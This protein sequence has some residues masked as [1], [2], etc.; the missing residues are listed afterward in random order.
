MQA[1]VHNYG[2]EYHRVLNYLKEDSTWGEPLSNSKV[3]RAEVIH[4]VREEMAQK[5]G[6][7]VLRRTDLGTGAYPGAPALNT[8]AEL[9]ASELGWNKRRTEKELDEVKCSFP[10]HTHLKQRVA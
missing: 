8:C 6:D 1:L 4:A 9:M 3:I 2:S 5:L 10:L 7:V